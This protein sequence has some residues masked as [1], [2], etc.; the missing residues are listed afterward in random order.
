[1]KRVIGDRM[2]YLGETY[3]KACAE[4]G[5]SECA[6]HR[7]D[8][9]GWD[10]KMRPDS[11]GAPSSYPI[12][13]GGTDCDDSIWLLVDEAEKRM[14][15]RMESARRLASVASIAAH[16]AINETADDVLVAAWAK[17]ALDGLPK[18]PILRTSDAEARFVAAFAGVRRALEAL[19][20]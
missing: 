14:D 2:E 1:M 5:C 9:G 19:V 4:D 11:D 17:S 6:F 16:P 8:R 3:R 15:A 12:E 10:C 18:L 13:D 20:P 7:P